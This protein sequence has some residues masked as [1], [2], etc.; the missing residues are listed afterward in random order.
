MKIS[1]PTLTI[2]ALTSV[3]GCGASPA[4]QPSDVAD[5]DSPGTEVGTYGKGA[6]PPGREGPG[7]PQGPGGRRGPPAEAVEAC[8]GLAESTACSF[9][10]RD[11]T[12]EGTCVRGPRD[13]SLACRPKGPPPDQR[14]SGD[15]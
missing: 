2:A 15:G 10:L 5:V 13:A 11:Q 1:L 14:S 8:K 6:R 9:E 4:M 12:V 7:G 3:V